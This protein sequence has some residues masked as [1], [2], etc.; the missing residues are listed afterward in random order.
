MIEKIVNNIE[1]FNA[2]EIKVSIKQAFN[3]RDIYAELAVMFATVS[4]KK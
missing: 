1:L 4:E 2:D 3:P